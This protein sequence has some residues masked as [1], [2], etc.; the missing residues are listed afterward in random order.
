MFCLIE[1]FR[2]GRPPLT[3]RALVEN[4]LLPGQHLRASGRNPLFESSSAGA[5]KF[6]AVLLTRTSARPYVAAAFTRG[7]PAATPHEELN[8]PGHEVGLQ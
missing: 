1:H 7:G 8:W 6:P 4:H 5:T 3:R 2:V